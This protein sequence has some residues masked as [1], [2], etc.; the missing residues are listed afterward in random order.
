M[1]KPTYSRKLIDN[2]G[3]LQITIPKDIAKKL[4]LKASASLVIWLEEKD[5]IVM[6]PAVDLA[7]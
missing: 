4:N 7:D 3:S 2:H 1:A 5:K 6:Q